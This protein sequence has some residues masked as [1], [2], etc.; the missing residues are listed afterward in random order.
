MNQMLYSSLSTHRQSVIFVFDL[1]DRLFKVVAC[2]RHAL[3]K[4][5]LYFSAEHQAILIYLDERMADTPTMTAGEQVFQKLYK[6]VCEERDQLAST[7]AM[8]ARMLETCAS[9]NTV[10]EAAANAA[11]QLAAEAKLE[12]EKSREERD[13]AILELQRVAGE[14][15]ANVATVQAMGAAVVAKLTADLAAAETAAATA[16]AESAEAV[17]RLKQE[18]DQLRAA[19]AKNCS[20]TVFQDRIVTLRRNE[21]RM[22]EQ[23]AVTAANRARDQLAAAADAEV[24]RLTSE[25]TKV[26]AD[27]A[28]I[29]K[30][31]TSLEGKVLALQ[32]AL[33][34]AEAA[35]A[36]RQSAARTA[37]DQLTLQLQQALA[38]RDESV[39]ARDELVAASHTAQ[40][41]LSGQFTAALAAANA[42]HNEAQNKLLD[43]LNGLTFMHNNE[44]ARMTGQLDATAA[45]L[46]AAQE[47]NVTLTRDL[48]EA[49]RQNTTATKNKNEALREQFLKLSQVAEAADARAAA[50]TTMLQQMQ[51]HGAQAAAAFLA[52]FEE[53]QNTAIVKTIFASG[54]QSDQEAAELRVKVADLESQLAAS[55]AKLLHRDVGA[56]EEVQ[57]LRNTVASLTSELQT[58]T[59]EVFRAQ[60]DKAK[61]EFASALAQASAL[62][63]AQAAAGLEEVKKM[64]AAM[65]LNAAD[66]AAVAS[67]KEQLQSA[68]RQLEQQQSSK[69]KEEVPSSTPVGQKRRR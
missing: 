47:R 33:T 49:R 1:W 4:E 50:A 59:K 30:H 52:K 6:D 42:A 38:E 66:V 68:L 54:N 10:I 64:Q 13:N 48:K 11:K 27:R 7:N 23:A 31:A 29:L 2:V 55:E 62:S 8:Y 9:Q 41:A 28:E 39:A 46:A 36:A 61:S 19:S 32:A 63:Q 56:Q 34:E 5:D 15:V 22:A 20:A 67:Y 14:A 58:V 65:A 3:H 51:Q 45:K 69:T 37:I 16:S 60:L 43:A 53:V 25:L 21:A 12:A 57:L 24:A 40:E 44:M 26:S 18:N 35:A 17:L